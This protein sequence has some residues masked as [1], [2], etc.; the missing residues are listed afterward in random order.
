MA[1]RST[2]SSSPST[3]TARG[4]HNG[5]RYFLDVAW[6]LV[7]PLVTLGLLQLA[8]VTRLTRTSLLDVLA[9]DFVRTVR[10]KGLRPR[11]VLYGH[12]LRNALL[13]VV[14]VDRGHV[15]TLLAGAVLTEIIFTWPGIGRP[16][17]RDSVV[18]VRPWL[19]CS[20]C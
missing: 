15:G 17:G 5:V 16:P 20:C 4:G 12:A 6:H 1:R 11:A 19:G 3:T 10:A 2:H 18:T 14:T 9:E 7:L 13:P 8:L